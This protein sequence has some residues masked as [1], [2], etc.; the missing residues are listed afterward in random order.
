MEKNL[1][2]QGFVLLDVDVVALNN[3]GLSKATNNDN[4][5]KTK[6]ITK[7]GSSYVYVSGQAWRY[8]WRKSLE[9]NYGW[10]MSPISFGKNKKIAYTS[11]DPVTYPDD[12]V[13]GYMKAEG[14]SPV[15]RVSP[16]KNSALISVAS[17]RP[18]V[19]WSNMMRQD[20][21]PVP[22]FREEYSAVLKGMFSVDVNMVGTFSSYNKSGFQNI[23]EDFKKKVLKSSGVVEI[24]DSVYNGTL[25]RL[26]LETRI[27]RI[28]D[29]L[30]AL[31]FISGG[32]IQTEDMSDVTPKFIVLAT[33]TTGNHPFSHIAVSSGDWDEKAILNV[34]GIEEVIN[35]YK[36][37]FV[38]KIFIGRR[39]G[40]FDDDDNDLKALADKYKDLVEYL[41]VNEAIDQYV[42]QIKEQMK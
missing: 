13:F 34:K 17:V 31:K 37:T 24:P 26:P 18:V 33:T 21:T 28:S 6:S 22:F 7:N 4:V 39:S 8:W 40:F 9:E 25:I 42:G 1:K 16:L 35:D 2:V 32:A 41:S 3:A 20:D 15:T 19:N 14:N 36:E 29:S 5:G 23:T 12:D 10:N 38:G 27:K 30:S 11:V